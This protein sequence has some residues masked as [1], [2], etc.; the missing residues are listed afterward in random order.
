MPQSVGITL[1]TPAALA[2]SNSLGCGSSSI[3]GMIALMRIST[4]VSVSLS[5]SGSSVTGLAMRISTPLAR[6]AATSGLLSE[7]L[8]AMTFY[9]IERYDIRCLLEEEVENRLILT[10]APDRRRPSTMDVP[11][12]PVAPTTRTVGVELR[13]VMVGLGALGSL[14]RDLYHL[15]G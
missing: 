15:H 6:R 9:E 10:K 11:V 14:Q 2:A 4:P 5:F 1:F 3:L 8:K 7:R 13:V 12:L